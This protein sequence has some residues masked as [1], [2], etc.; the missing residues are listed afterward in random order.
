MQD[1]LATLRL[2]PRA[3]LLQDEAYAAMRDDISSPFLK[4]LILI[5]V[6]GVVVSA[7]AIVGETLEWATT[8][9]LGAIKD[10]VLEGLQQMPWYG[11][12]S[13]STPDFEST[14]R[15]QYDMG[16]RFFPYAFGAPNPIG[17][18]V[19]VIVIPLRL[20]VSWLVFGLLGYLFAR[21][22]GG[23]SSLD[24][25]LG[26][27]ALAVAPQLLGLLHILPYVEV[28]SVIT[29]WTLVSN[30]LALKNAHHLSSK[31]AFWATLLPF[32]FL[33]LL[34]L[35]LGGLGVFLGLNLARG[36]R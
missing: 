7:A 2:C 4:G 27:T 9:D 19:G 12:A 14:F 15:Q 28:G 35:I 31:R 29:I 26:C 23:Q 8:P 33:T 32:I 1:F 22:L 20:G 17:A 36:G 13:K 6:V 30:Y 3:L 5:L 21:L 34:G 11:E 25:T 16:W 18:A 10:V 24:Q